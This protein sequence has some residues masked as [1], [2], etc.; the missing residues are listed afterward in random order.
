MLWTKHQDT[1]S[2]TTRTTWFSF[3]WLSFIEL[4]KWIVH[5]WA[6]SINCFEINV[7]TWIILSR[8]SQP[9]KFPSIYWNICCMSVSHNSN[10]Q[11]FSQMKMTKAMKIDT[12]KSMF[13]FYILVTFATIGPMWSMF[14]MFTQNWTIPCDETHHEFVRFL[15][16]VINDSETRM[17]C[18][19]RFDGEGNLVYF[20]KNHFVTSHR[21]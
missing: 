8:S 9:L 6:W 10:S 21:F 20:T 19:D 18:V 14:W 5:F 12:T 16:N 11:S 13:L 4:K 7:V 2:N 3:D 17:C 15:K 1:T